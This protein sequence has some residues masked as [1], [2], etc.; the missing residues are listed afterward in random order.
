VKS[1]RGLPVRERRITWNYGNVEI[2]LVEEE[3]G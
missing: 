1:R 3:V 2:N